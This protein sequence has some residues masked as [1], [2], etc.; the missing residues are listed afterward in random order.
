MLDILG[1]GGCLLSLKNIFAL[2]W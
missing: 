1:C 2:H